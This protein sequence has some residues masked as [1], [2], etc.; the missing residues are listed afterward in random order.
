MSSVPDNSNEYDEEP[1]SYTT[2][3]ELSEDELKDIS[4]G[5]LN[6][7]AVFNG[8]EGGPSSPI[9]SQ[10]NSM[11]SSSDEDT[12]ELQQMMQKWTISTQLQS[13]SEKTVSTGIKSTVKNIR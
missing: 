1:E 3:I 4:A 5:A 13:E 11:D 2:D 6:L 7:D 9:E 10:G 12:Q 8:G